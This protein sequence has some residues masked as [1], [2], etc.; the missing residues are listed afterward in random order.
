M[1]KGFMF[2]VVLVLTSLQLLW[3]ESK[4]SLSFAYLHLPTDS[5]CSLT[6]RQGV[7]PMLP[8]PLGSSLLYTPLSPPYPCAL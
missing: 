4:P 3:E 1:F 2:L 6:W 5:C 8:V 7:Q